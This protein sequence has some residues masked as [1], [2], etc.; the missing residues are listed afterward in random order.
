MKNKWL[1]LVIKYLDLNSCDITSCLYNYIDLYS[2]FLFSFSYITTMT[3][4]LK[5]YILTMMSLI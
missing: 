2:I 1:K 4:I 3:N 5:I